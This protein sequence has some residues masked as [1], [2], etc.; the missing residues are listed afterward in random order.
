MPATQLH[1][2]QKVLFVGESWIKHIVHMKGFDQFTSVEYQEGATYLLENLEE[3]GVDID[4]VRSHEIGGRFPR[5]ANELEKFDVVVLS[6]IGA[7]SFQLTDDTFLRSIAAPDRLALVRDYVRGG[8]GLVMIGGYMSFSGIDGRARYS[9]SPL[10]DVL[11]VEM[12][13]TDDRVELP[14][15]EVPVLERPDH[16]VIGE[17]TGS[18][19]ALLGYNQVVARAGSEVVASINGDPLLVVG[20]YGAGRVAAFTSDVAPHWAPQSFLDWDGYLPL[21]QSILNW[22]SRTKVVPE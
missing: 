21:W 15:G 12:V 3:R 10:R 5:A 6:D 9:M 19:P 17:Q 16:A 22:T 18:W 11:P 14:Q 7:N 13:A 1:D 20:T 8:G 4:Y 2:A